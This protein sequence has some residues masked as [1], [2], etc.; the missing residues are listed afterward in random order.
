VRWYVKALRQYA[1]FS[2]RAQRAEY[3]MFSLISAIISIALS[4]I[5]SAVLGFGLDTSAPTGGLGPLGWLYNLAVLLPTIAV[6]ARRLHDCGHS[7][8]WQLLSAP[9]IVVG[10]GLREP[11]II[12]LIAS[13]VGIIGGFILLV[14]MVTDGTP[15]PN[16]WGV[17]P[18][19]G[20]AGAPHPSIG[21]DENPA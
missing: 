7:G 8:W 20:V 5:D 2:G 19:V 9:L 1:D 4:V 15:E 12:S 10:L 17:N 14:M 11:L 6:G 13:A 3:W 16:R 18:K 21:A